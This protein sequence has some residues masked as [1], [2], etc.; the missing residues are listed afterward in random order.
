MARA[1]RVQDPEVRFDGQWLVRRLAPDCSRIELSTL[2]TE[3][4][5]RRLLYCM[6][7]ETANLHLATP[8]ATAAV[9]RDLARRGGRWLHKAAKAMA[10]ACLADWDEWRTGWRRRTR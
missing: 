9:K 2:P 1:I 4:D 3:R 7:W 10:K 6:G 5:E 8:R